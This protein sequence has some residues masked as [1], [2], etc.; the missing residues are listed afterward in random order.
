MAIELEVGTATITSKN[1]IVIPK[2]AREKFNL[3]EGQKL[4]VF[5]G[6]HEVILSPFLSLDQLCGIL[7][8]PQTAEELVKE[9]R[10]NISR[11]D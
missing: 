7:K 11:Y 10:K 1:M 4:K 2:K 9:G 5:V 3:Q 8:G 6:E